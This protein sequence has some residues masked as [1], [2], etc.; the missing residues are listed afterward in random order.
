MGTGALI[1]VRG[2]PPGL[3]ERARHR[4]EALEARWS[5]FLPTS[6]IS[7]LNGQPHGRPT[8][9]SAD[10]YR[11]VDT[12]VTAWRRTEGRYDPTVL[13]AMHA[14]GYDRT[15]DTIETACSPTDAPGPA[16]GCSGIILDP[17]LHAILLPHGV[18]IDPGGI[19]KGFAADLVATELLAAGA[20]GALVDLG[21]D[22]RVVGDGPHDGAWVVDVEDP[23]DPHHSLLHIALTDAAIATS[24]IRRRR[25]TTTRGERHH[26]LD[27]AT[28]LPLSTPLVA[29]TVIASDGWWAE[30]L[31]KAILV[32][33]DLT[34]VTHAAALAID[35]H[36][37][38]HI[39]PDLEVLAA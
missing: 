6:E 29:A 10:T 25:W 13:A 20:D 23:A 12:A 18:G 24:S 15:F 34:P 7:R 37:A 35:A 26:L 27:P 31:T 19:G 39:T 36:G 30:A 2:G 1:I 38:R 11:L 8:I 3:A 14:N 28:G 5:R 17:V 32:A 21:G 4:V 33:G 9:V 22:I 16:P